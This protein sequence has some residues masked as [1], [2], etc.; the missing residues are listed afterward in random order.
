ME[1]GRAELYV[2]AC[3][4]TWNVQM[5]VAKKDQRLV[6]TAMFCLPPL[7]SPTWENRVRINQSSRLLRDEG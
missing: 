1:L 4:G 7:P 5:G 2:A 3:L 6:Q